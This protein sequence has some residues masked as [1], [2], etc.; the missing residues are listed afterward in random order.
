MSTTTTVHEVI[1]KD[2]SII[3]IEILSDGAGGVFRLAHKYDAEKDRYVA[4]CIGD[5]GVFVAREQGAGNTVISFGQ[6]IESEAA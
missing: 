3:A 2:P 1:Q 6:E 4:R 5:V